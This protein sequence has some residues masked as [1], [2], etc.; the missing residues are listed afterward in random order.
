[1]TLYDEERITLSGDTPLEDCDGQMHIQRM[2]SDSRRMTLYDEK[3][4]W[5]EEKEFGGH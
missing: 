4:S 1:M 2:E 3:E 5:Y